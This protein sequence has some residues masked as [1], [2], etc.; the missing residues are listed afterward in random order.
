MPDR[1]V[2]VAELVGLPVEQVCIGSCTN[3]SYADLKLVAQILRRG[4]ASIP[5]PTP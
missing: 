5:A 2:P 1:V 4:T 3:S